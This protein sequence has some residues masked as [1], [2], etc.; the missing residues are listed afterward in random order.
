[1]RLWGGLVIGLIETLASG[2]ISTGLQDVSAFIVI[3][4]VLVVIADRSVRRT[5]R[6]ARLTWVRSLAATP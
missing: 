4:F 1:M 3:M 5:P 2:Y 6:E